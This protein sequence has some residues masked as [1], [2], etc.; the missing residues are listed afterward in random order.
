MNLF[1]LKSESLLI[2]S[3][4]NEFT[5][6]SESFVL[7]DEE[8][9]FEPIHRF[10]FSQLR[11]M[12]ESGGEVS[13]ATFLAR[14]RL[15]DGTTESRF[16]ETLGN[17]PV[18]PAA[19]FDIAKSV[20]NFSLLRK[21]QDLSKL[22]NSQSSDPINDPL[23]LIEKYTD[24]LLSFSGFTKTDQPELIRDLMHS[25]VEKIDKIRS[26]QEKTFGI[27]TSID[28]I[29]ECTG[30]LENGQLYVMA[31]RPSVG[32]TSLMLSIVKNICTHFPS[33]IFSLEMTAEQ[34]GL[35]LLSQ[36]SGISYY[37][38]K[39]GNIDAEAARAYMNS[40]SKISEYKLHIDPTSNLS[41]YELRSKLSKLKREN[42]TRVVFIDY[43]G[44]MNT[45]KLGTR[46]LE[47]GYITK[48]LKSI[49]KEENM[50][51]VLL[52]QLNRGVEDRA[53]K[54]P[55]LRDLRESGNIEQD[56]D[57]VIFIHRDRLWQGEART[58]KEPEIIIGKNRNGKIGYRD[59]VFLEETMD[60]KNKEIK[61]ETPAEMTKD[62]TN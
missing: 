1:D 44:L 22:I 62:W 59:V 25:V 41:V 16:I 53:D 28:I 45:P 55:I 10:W 26:G 13:P 40:A 34:I 54:R 27:P 32:K 4:V 31:A 49:A 57:V 29:D 61:R 52:C 14:L 42:G 47:I 9:F 20:K 19:T 15:K 60:F 5:P 8:D 39:N 23:E 38:L 58:G 50:P 11:G 30:G 3:L 46:D 24:K 56:A 51:I 33:V 2:S 43:L 37:N 7:I 17:Y 21:L 18:S 12:Y 48:N 36:A 6:N 35:R